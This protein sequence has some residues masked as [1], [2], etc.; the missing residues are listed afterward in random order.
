MP[1]A[2]ETE[3]GIRQNRQRRGGCVSESWRGPVGPAGK[4]G[5]R[6]KRVQIRYEC[7][8]VALRIASKENAVA[9]APSRFP[10]KATGGDP[11]PDRELRTTSRAMV[12]DHCR[13]T[14]VD[15][16]SG[17]KWIN[18]WCGQ[19]RSPARCAFGGPL[20]KGLLRLFPRIDLIDLT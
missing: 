19:F 20:P 17:D 11:Y 12:V 10:F 16:M 3:V 18:A 1:P 4:V 6:N 13:G 8:A 9:E 14:D 2:R 5:A 15:T 7:T